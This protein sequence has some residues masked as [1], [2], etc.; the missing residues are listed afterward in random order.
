VFEAGANEWRS[1]DSWPPRTG[2][3][4]RQLY[5]HAGSRLSF[6][7]PVA[8]DSGSDVYV[9]DPARPVPYRVRPIL[10]TFDDASTWSTWLVDDQRFAQDRPDVFA[11]ETA[12]LEE[13]VVIAGDITAHLFAATS[14]SD[15]DWV[16]KL[17]DVYPER[18][19]RDP[20]LS[21]YHLMVANDVFRGRYRKG[22]EHP[23][24]IVPNQVEEYTIDLHSQNYRFLKGHRIKVQV[25]STW[26]PL[27]DRN[28][29]T[30][31]PNIFA[32]KESD[33]RPA[34]QRVFRSPGSASFIQLS[35]LRGAPIP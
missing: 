27:I 1:F 2:V 29:Q 25:Q 34:T 32:A 30:F 8:S 13:D 7:P 15:A 12:P 14:G 23:E 19:E 24:A 28:P 18:Y 31:V 22:F 11:W 33:F 26:F 4:Q 17:I 35:V 6:E 16:V 9:S 10:P 3:A 21:G 20:K 5:F